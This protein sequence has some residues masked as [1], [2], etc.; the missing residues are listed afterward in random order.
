[1]KDHRHPQKHSD[2]TRPRESAGSLIALVATLL[3]CVQYRSAC[4]IIRVMDLTPPSV[5]TLETVPPL[6]NT[7]FS[8]PLLPK[9]TLHL[10]DERCSCGKR[11]AGKCFGV[12]AV[13]SATRRLLRLASAIC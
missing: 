4:P 12:A 3:F 6:I 7:L 1:M 2:T 9:A 5:F 8:A 10:P 13:L 11:P